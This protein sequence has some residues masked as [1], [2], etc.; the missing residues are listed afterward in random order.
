MYCVSKGGIGFLP[1][2]HV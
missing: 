1:V 2:A